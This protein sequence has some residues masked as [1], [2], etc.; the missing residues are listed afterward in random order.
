MKKKTQD[1]RFAQADKEAL[2]SLAAYGLYFVW[3]YVC[4]YGLGSGDPDQYSYVWGL[5]SWFFYSCIVGYPLITVL[6]WGIVRFKFREMPLDDDSETGF[7]QDVP[8]ATQAA[9]QEE[10]RP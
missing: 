1:P 2:L 7:G 4:A 3:W 5:P 6:L 9:E 10:G 8:S